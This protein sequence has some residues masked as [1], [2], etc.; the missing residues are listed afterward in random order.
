MNELWVRPTNESNTILRTGRHNLINFTI[1]EK[2]CQLY[3]EAQ[4]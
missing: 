1:F 4:Q 2:F 3:M